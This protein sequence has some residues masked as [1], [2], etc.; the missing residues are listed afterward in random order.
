MILDK[1]DKLPWR[2]PFQRSDYTLVFF[3]LAV[4]EEYWYVED[5]YLISFLNVTVYRRVLIF[6]RFHEFDFNSEIYFTE[7]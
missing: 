4:C 7:N 5:L 3:Y 1:V 2:Q 6:C